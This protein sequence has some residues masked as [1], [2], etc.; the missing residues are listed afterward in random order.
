MKKDY[1][2]CDSKTEIM[3]RKTKLPGRGKPIQR[4]KPPI[5]K[6]KNEFLPEEIKDLPRK[7]IP[8]VSKKQQKNLYAY[9]QAKKELFSQSDECML[10]IPD[11]CTGVATDSHHRKGRGIYIAVKGLLARACRPCH[12]WCGAHPQEAID[13]GY[14]LRRNTALNEK[15]LPDTVVSSG[16]NNVTNGSNEQKNTQHE[17]NV[18]NKP[19]TTPKKKSPGQGAQFS[20][21]LITTHNALINNDYYGE[22]I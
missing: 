8:L 2:I 7:K 18:E 9:S 19:H 5:R 17:E 11:V 21:F 1:L 13:R 12:D 22:V 10:Q 3:L 6:K 14:S 20:D 15:N 4:S 16:S